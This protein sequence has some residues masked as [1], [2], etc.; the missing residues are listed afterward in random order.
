MALK[1]LRV[2]QSSEKARKVRPSKTVVT[3]L[4]YTSLPNGQELEQE[5][6]KWA[7]LQHPNILPLYGT[8]DDGW[9]LYLVSESPRDGQRG[10]DSNPLGV[11]MVRRWKSAYLRQENPPTG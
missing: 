10:V 5:L 8:I 11:T 3:L 9:R 2:H 1:T 7:G 4:I 6:P